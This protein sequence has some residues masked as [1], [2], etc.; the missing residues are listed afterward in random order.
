MRDY[1]P[2]YSRSVHSLP[3][4]D[5]VPLG[6]LASA[7]TAS[8]RIPHDSRWFQGHFDGAPI[9]PG[10]THLALALAACD[11]EGGHDLKG[12][13]EVRF[14]HPILPG[15]E[16]EVRLEQGADPATRRYQVRCR[17]RVASS[18]VLVLVPRGDAASG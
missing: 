7:W 10:V 11:P 4:R 6:G 8:F 16:V 14:N 12:V 15:D 13:R 1:Y 3:L 18:G 5:L 17:G 2:I 9:L